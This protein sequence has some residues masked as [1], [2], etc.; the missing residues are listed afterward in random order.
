MTTYQGAL[1]L[2]STYSD[3]EFTLAELRDI[4]L[5]GG[6]AFAC[7]TDHAEAFDAAKLDA[8]RAECRTLSDDRF[9]FIAG[10]EYSCCQRLHVLGYGVTSLL[11]TTEPQEVIAAIEQRGGVSVI[12]HPRDAHF[13]WIE[14][15]EHLPGGIETWNSKYDGR[16]APRPG[17]FA[18]LQTLRRRKPEMQA[19]YGQDLHWKK[20]FR[21]LFI[22]IDCAT[23]EPTAIL[24]AL[25]AGAYTASKDNLHLP[26]S[27]IVPDELLA[28][29]GR[30]HARSQRMWRFLKGGKAALD[31][32]GFHVPE[33]L[34][35]QLRR[36][37]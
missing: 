6:C 29:F 12:A 25:S 34:K 14:E 22:T 4:F 19:F 3:G 30:A 18:L 9:R 2:H 23:P 11:Q 26:S 36:V 21:G 31:R 28:E 35:A 8:Y 33:S 1:H 15:F 27:G 7:M 17:T 32:L 16:Y 24:S 10:L 13:A 5:A 20:Q 37:F